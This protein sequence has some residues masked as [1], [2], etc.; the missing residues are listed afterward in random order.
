MLH[1]LGYKCI[2]YIIHTL[3][4]VD[5]ITT[6]IFVC[7]ETEGLGN[8]LKVTQGGRAQIQT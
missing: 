5:T 6:F 2:V 3:Y 4:V 8:L 7:E 1:Q